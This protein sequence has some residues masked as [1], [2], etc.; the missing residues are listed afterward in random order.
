MLSVALHIESL[1]SGVFSNE[2]S[3]SQRK[4]DDLLSAEASSNIAV[5]GN[6]KENGDLPVTETSPHIAAVVD[7]TTNKNES[8][9]V[10]MDFV[11][12]FK[13][14]RAE[15]GKRMNWVACLKEGKE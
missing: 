3:V 13:Q 10:A 2:C 5:T 1:T 8:Y 14:D 4:Y 7:Q 6:N 11:A 12:K 9:E 15:K